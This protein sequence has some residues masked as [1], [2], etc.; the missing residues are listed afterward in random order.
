MPAAGFQE[1]LLIGDGEVDACLR[2]RDADL[3]SPDADRQKRA[4]GHPNTPGDHP[5]RNAQAA[6]AAG[7][8]SSI[9]RP[10]SRLG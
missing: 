4:G 3:R 9:F 7:T 8:Y 1:A 2:S 10:L 6:E 5:G